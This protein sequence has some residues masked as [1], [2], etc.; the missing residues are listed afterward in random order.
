MWTASAGVDVADE[1]IFYAGDLGT[2]HLRRDVALRDLVVPVEGRLLGVHNCVAQTTGEPMTVLA[3]EAEADSPWGPPERALT[4]SADTVVVVKPEVPTV[5]ELTAHE[6]DV[7]VKLRAAGF[8]DTTI[9]LT[10][11]AERQDSASLEA[12]CAAVR[13]VPGA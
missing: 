4:V 11:S 12:V 5:L 9:G 13:A 10:V 6:V 3:L 7:V 1:R 8:S 2:Q